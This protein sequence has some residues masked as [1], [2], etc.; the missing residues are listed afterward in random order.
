[1]FN[2]F[3]WGGYL[4]FRLYPNQKVFL[5]SQSDFYGEDLI[6]EYD[7]VIRVDESWENILQQH[8]ISWAIVPSNSRI[9]KALVSQLQWTIL[10][11]DSTA[12]II[13]KP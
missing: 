4:I 2:D 12:A 8:N 11:E 10:Y 13:A 1:M 5:D 3:N 7:T 6:R 9:G